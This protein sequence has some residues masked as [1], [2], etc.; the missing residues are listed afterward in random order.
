MQGVWWIKHL[1]YRLFVLLDLGAQLDKLLLIAGQPVL[2]FSKL[3]AQSQDNS[4]LLPLLPLVKF[5]S[6]FPSS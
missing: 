4:M 6:R 2:Y 1:T 3:Y 5:R